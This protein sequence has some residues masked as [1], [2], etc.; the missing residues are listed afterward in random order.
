MVE[1]AIRGLMLQRL[2]GLLEK[3]RRS[4]QQIIEEINELRLLLIHFSPMSPKAWRHLVEEVKHGK[5]GLRM[6]HAEVMWLL[7]EKTGGL[8]TI[9]TLS[10]LLREA[11]LSVEKDEQS[12][13][14]NLRSMINEKAQLQMPWKMFTELNYGLYYRNDKLW[15][16][17]DRVELSNWEEDCLARI[18]EAVSWISNVRE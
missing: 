3:Q 6:T 12:L 9:Q 1:D 17:K 15:Q 7:S 13:R 14:S 16:A 11:G 4:S 8:L 5:N 18:Q 10:R 2:D